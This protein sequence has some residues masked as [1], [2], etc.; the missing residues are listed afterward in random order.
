MNFIYKTC[1][2]LHYIKFSLDFYEDDNKLL[3]TFYNFVV[4]CTLLMLLQ[5]SDFLLNQTQKFAAI[6]LCYE[7]YRNE[8]IATN[9]LAPVFMHLLVRHLLHCN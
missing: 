6:I 8:P 3:C 4:G 5:H 7:L 9:P 2:F 1:L